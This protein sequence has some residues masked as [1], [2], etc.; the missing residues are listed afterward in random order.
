M[1]RG[2]PSGAYRPDSGHQ[3]N[4]TYISLTRKLATHRTGIRAG[5]DKWHSDVRTEEGDTGQNCDR[6]GLA[7]R[8]Q[9]VPVTLSVMSVIQGDSEAPRMC[10]HGGE[11]R[12][13]P[14]PARLSGMSP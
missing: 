11:G 6:D 4:L 9:P 10:M 3:M 1:F 14:G 8:G 12:R 7:F 2:A 5:E 13:G